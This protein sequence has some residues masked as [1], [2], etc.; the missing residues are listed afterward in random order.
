MPAVS[1]TWELRLASACICLL[2]V[3]AF[4]D[5]RMES[6]NLKNS[7]SNLSVINPALDKY[8]PSESDLGLRIIAATGRYYIALAIVLA[9]NIIAKKTHIK[10]SHRL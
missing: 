1:L 7:V 4:L 10:G 8:F 6:L 9:V 2:S 5:L 3:V